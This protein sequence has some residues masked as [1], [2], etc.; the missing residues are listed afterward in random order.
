MK[1]DAGRSSSSVPAPQSS[2][3]SPVLADLLSRQPLESTWAVLLLEYT[4]TMVH[5]RASLLLMT[6]QAT[7]LTLKWTID[8]TMTLIGASC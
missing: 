7:N 5:N 4:H 8:G 1:F 3:V 2:C 6:L